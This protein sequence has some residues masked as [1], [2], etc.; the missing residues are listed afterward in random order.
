MKS[1]TART[2]RDKSTNEDILEKLE[3][4]AASLEEDMLRNQYAGRTITV[5]YK[6]HDY[7]CGL[8]LCPAYLLT[9]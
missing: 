9:T 6:S 5:K 7:K 2:F 1:L 8:A 3:E 4:I